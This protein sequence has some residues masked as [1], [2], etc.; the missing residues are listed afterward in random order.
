M[1][2]ISKKA[3]ERHKTG[4]QLLAKAEKAQPHVDVTQK[5]AYPIS[6][7]DEI[8]SNPTLG[9]SEV[10]GIQP[11]LCGKVCAAEVVIW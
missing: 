10:K 6:E 9:S 3:L 1:Q 8:P 4:Q 2:K 5:K 11:G 7:Q